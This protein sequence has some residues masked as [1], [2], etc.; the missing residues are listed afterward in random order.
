MKKWT[1]K[2]GEIWHGDC[3]KVLK[4]LKPASVDLVFGSP[5]YEDARLY[6]ENGEDLQISRKTKEWVDWMVEVYKESLRVC[7]GLVAFVVGHGKGARD[8]SAA[9]AFLICALKEAGITVRS[10]C[11]YHRHGI[12]GS[13]GNDWLRADLEWIICTTNDTEK[14]PWS[15]NVACGKPPKYGP[16]GP[17]SHRRIDGKRVN[18]LMQAEGISKRDAARRLGVKST[19]TS[20]HK[21]GDVVSLKVHYVPPERSNPGN[22]ISGTVGG[23]Q[24]GSDLAHDNEAPFPEWLADFFVRSFCPPEGKV[25]DPFGGSGTTLSVAIKTGRKFVSCDMRMS[26]IEL[27]FKRRIEA[28]GKSGFKFNR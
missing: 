6:L 20:G 27:M 25:F 26:Q 11:W 5:P 19:N 13:G 3:L 9:P 17:P 4:K 24:M 23:G 10:P 2:E 28:V 18:D 15:N 22:V 16:G 1:F 14:L 12:M 8:W 7:K 21:N